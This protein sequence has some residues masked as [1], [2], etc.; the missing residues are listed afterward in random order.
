VRAAPLLAVAVLAAPLAGCMATSSG[1]A[2]VVVTGQPVLDAFL[3]LDEE[4]QLA[5]IPDW[6]A[7]DS[8]LAAERVG[9]PFAIDPET[10]VRLE[11]RLVLD[12][13]HPL[14]SGPSRE[15]LADGVERA[16]IPY[17]TAPVE[18]E[19]S[20]VRAT[21]D[22]AAEASGTDPDPAWSSVQEDLAEVN[23]SLEGVPERSALVLFPAGLVAGEGTDADRVLE[24]AGLSNLAAE[25]GLEGYRQI[26][27]EAVQRSDVDRVLATS[28]RGETAAEIAAKPM[29]EGT[30]VEDEP[31]RVLVVD[32]SR[33]T[34]LGPQVVD[35]AERVATW[36]HPE[37][38][39]PRVQ[40]TVT[41]L[42]APACDTV[43]VDVDAPNAMVTWQ[44]TEHAPGEVDLGDVEPGHYRLYVHGEDDTGTASITQL[45]SVEG[46]T[47][48]S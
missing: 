27:D 26:T 36:A 46:S 37:L 23:A 25:A 39:G 45:V 9:R 11:P 16:G 15:A 22:A 47:C 38:P 44:G 4:D 43:T 7:T 12:Q 42:E 21:L 35:A 2:G 17:E 5:A 18:P 48:A 32:P 1:G 41:P 8:P 3:A 14:V 24:L 20:T 34:R 30:P 6:A 29:F 40:A 19:L 33:T 10:V 28:T 13:P 31:D